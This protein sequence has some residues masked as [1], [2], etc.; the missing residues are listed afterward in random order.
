MPRSSRK[1][2]GTLSHYLERQIICRII[3]CGLYLRLLR[4]LRLAGY[5]LLLLPRSRLSGSRSSCTRIS[6]FRRQHF[7]ICLLYTSNLCQVELELSTLSG[8]RYQELFKENRKQ[9]LPAGILPFR[10]CIIQTVEQ[11]LFLTFHRWKH[12]HL[13]LI[14]I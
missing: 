6:S 4:L 1:P 14:H 7:H 8:P 11:P 13:S 12:Q 9:L 5:R 2:I 10:F 3:L